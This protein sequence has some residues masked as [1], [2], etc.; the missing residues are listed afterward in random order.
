MI[1]L[2]GGTG[3]AGRHLALQLAAAGRP[4]RILSRAPD[5]A[6]LPPHVAFAKGD[7]G[8]PA[9]LRSALEGVDT[10]VHAAAAVGDAPA[11]DLQRLNVDGTAALARA[12]RAGGVRRFVHLSS[13]GV[14]GDGPGSAPHR[15]GGPTRAATPYERSKL[16]AEGALL[17]ALGDS[18]VAWTILRPTGLYGPDRPATAAQFRDIARRRLWLHGTRRVVLHPTHVS[19]LVCVVARLLEGTAAH[20]EILNVGGERALEYQEL[21]DLV[22][23]RLGRMLLQLSAPALSRVSRAVDTS[24]VRALLGCPTKPLVAGVDETLAAL[25]LSGSQPTGS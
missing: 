16:A 2:T 17:E 13:A 11:A 10:V 14:Y 3:F 24:R 21:I 22:A 15:E 23:A 7:L 4:V 5:A 1:L 8:D 18:P 12:A 20:G 6:R 9:S 19:D 25:G